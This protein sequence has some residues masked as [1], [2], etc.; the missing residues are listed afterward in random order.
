MVP[1]FVAAPCFPE[2]VDNTALD[3]ETVAR[4]HWMPDIVQQSGYPIPKLEES[5]APAVFTELESQKPEIRIKAVYKLVHMRK[6]HKLG[7]REKEVIPALRNLLK[8]ENKSVRRVA[9]MGLVKIDPSLAT[10]LAPVFIET[11]RDGTQ[12][13]LRDLAVLFCGELRIKEAVPEIIELTKQQKPELIPR[14][15]YMY[16]DVL[17][18]IG[19]SEALEFSY[20][21]LWR[22]SGRFVTPLDDYILTR[23]WPDFLFLSGFIWLFWRSRQA[24][25]SGIKISYRPLL[26]TVFVWGL[27]TVDAISWTYHIDYP[28]SLVLFSN[29]VAKLT[30]FSPGSLPFALVLGTL[31]G[32][33][34]WL[35]SFLKLERSDRRILFK[36]AD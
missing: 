25:R 35:V 32:I 3:P 10:E 9:A 14:K 18:A 20:W 23:T 30:Y 24:R 21:P 2:P 11:I 34:P 22:V 26:I 29:M 31:L 28:D 33:I 7:G 6:Y 8:S 13:E 15:T 27:Q 4:L 17:Q 1:F 19:T 12:P 16:Y 36:W 5:D